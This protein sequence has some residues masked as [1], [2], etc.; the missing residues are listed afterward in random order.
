MSHPTDR[1]NTTD[2]ENVQTAIRSLAWIITL[3]LGVIAALACMLAN[4]RPVGAEGYTGPGCVTWESGASGEICG[5]DQGG[6]QDQG[7]AGQ[8]SGQGV[9][10]EPPSTKVNMENPA[11]GS[12]QSGISVI[13]G[14]VCEADEVKI[15]IRE[16]GGSWYTPLYV[17][18]TAYGTER[19]DTRRVC[20]DT[21]NGFG[22]LFNWNLLG[23][24]EYRVSLQVDDQV[25]ARASV[26]VVTFGLEFAEHASDA[27]YRLAD[28]PSDGEA[29]WVQ[30]D[31]AK[32][33][34]TI[35]RAE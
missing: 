12:H 11:E 29:A 25:L 18:G 14:W 5:S 8:G 33:N 27:I 21:D 24:G 28:F 13:S 20:G 32:Q 35:V 30:W 23:D 10:H 4:P 1:I 3:A 19:E 31:E 26:T 34:F 17:I 2:P 22:V 15:L 9:Q 16:K 6:G 7:G